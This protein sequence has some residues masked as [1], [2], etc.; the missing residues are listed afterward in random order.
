MRRFKALHYMDEMNEV[1]R[2]SE[3]TIIQWAKDDVANGKHEGPEPETV[4]EAM[5]ILNDIGDLQV[6]EDISHD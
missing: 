1:Q 5:D 2:P 4:E 3:A 6:M